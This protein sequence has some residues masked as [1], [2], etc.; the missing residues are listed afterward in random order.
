VFARENSAAAILDAIRARR[1]VVY[2]RGGKAYGD[3]GLIDLAKDRPE[4]RHA[5]TTDAPVSLLD[6]I[7]RILGLVGLAGLVKAAQRD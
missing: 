4:L 5:A 3:P 7:S 6:W 2:G 1:T